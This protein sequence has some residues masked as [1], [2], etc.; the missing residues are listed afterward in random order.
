ML[1]ARP[2]V[3]GATGDP[4]NPGGASKVPHRLER[5]PKPGLYEMA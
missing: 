3:V 5:Y 1:W 4:G 2:R